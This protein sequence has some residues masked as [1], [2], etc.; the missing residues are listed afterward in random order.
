VTLFAFV[1][2]HYS[3]VKDDYTYAL[4][5]LIREVTGFY[6]IAAL[7]RGYV[8]PHFVGTGDADCGI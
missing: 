2:F 6:Q 4:S 1:G 5:R 7:Q 3:K 8:A